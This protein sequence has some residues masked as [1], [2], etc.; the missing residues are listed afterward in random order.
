M[1]QVIIVS[2]FLHA[3]VS[4][5]DPAPVDDGFDVTDVEADEYED[6]DSEL[7]VATS[8]P[9]TLPVPAAG[10]SPEIDQLMAISING[11]QQDLR[12]LLAA[13]NNAV[14]RARITG[15]FRTTDTPTRLQASAVS[16]T[17]VGAAQVYRCNG[18]TWVFQRPEAGL[19]P[20]LVDPAQPASPPVAVSDSTIRDHYRHPG[21]AAAAAAGPAWR[22]TANTVDFG[23]FGQRFVG[24]TTAAGFVSVSNPGAPTTAIPLLR[25]PASTQGAAG[26]QSFTSN[27]S[28][29]LPSGRGF[30]LRLGTVGGRAPASCTASQNGQELRVP[31]STDYYFVQLTES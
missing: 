26:P 10:V 15:A 2:L 1:H 6:D 17:S 14:P 29:N 8:N 23:D 3:S 12:A 21:D 13:G 25:V 28:G 18:S 11:V 27:L 24:S 4:G 19:L 20:L 16:T 30:V 31:Y 22:L 9:T 5:C 7:R